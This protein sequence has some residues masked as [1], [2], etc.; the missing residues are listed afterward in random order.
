MS[1]ELGAAD[2]RTGD[3]TVAG[4]I[5][6]PRQPIRAIEPETKNRRMKRWN[7]ETMNRGTEKADSHAARKL[8]A[9]PHTH[10]Y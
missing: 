1:N 7:G 3:S 2:P 6:A 8:H 10:T 9:H 4:T 5:D